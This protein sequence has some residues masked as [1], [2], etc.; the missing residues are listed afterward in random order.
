MKIIVGIII[1]II[2]CILAFA[3]PGYWSGI[4]DCGDGICGPSEEHKDK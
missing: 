3:I 1:L 4:D 2:C